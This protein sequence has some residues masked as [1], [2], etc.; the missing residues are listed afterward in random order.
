[1]FSS[2][3]SRR[4]PVGEPAFQ[5]SMTICV[6]NQ[7]IIPNLKTMLQRVNPSST[8]PSPKYEEGHLGRFSA[9]GRQNK[10][11][12]KCDRHFFFFFFGCCHTIS[13]PFA[14][15]FFS[16]YIVSRH[17]GWQFFRP[18]MKTMKMTTVHK[19]YTV[20]KKKNMEAIPFATTKIFFLE[21]F[22]LLTLKTCHDLA[23]IGDAK[24]SAWTIFSMM[25]GD[26]N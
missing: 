24:I 19:K 22:C 23:K 2:L 14:F 21:I 18:M 5:R 4:S 9:N 25:S 17:H 11:K 20:L 7:M 3:A 16:G 15:N 8:H 10:E 26:N 6:E 13:Y 1:M 12:N